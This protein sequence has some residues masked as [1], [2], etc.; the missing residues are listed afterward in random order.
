[1]IRGADN[2]IYIK[3]L[4]LLTCQNFCIQDITL[5]RKLAT[6][7]S[8]EIWLKAGIPLLQQDPRLP[9]PL[10]IGE[11]TLPQN[12]KVIMTITSLHAD[13][14]Y[15]QSPLTQQYNLLSSW[16][17]LSIKRCPNRQRKQLTPMS[18]SRREAAQGS[19]RA[20][21]VNALQKWQSWANRWTHDL[22]GFQ[23]ICL[24]L[25]SHTRINKQ[26]HHTC[27]LFFLF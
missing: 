11:R 15:Y 10:K 4:Y 24:V 7:T 6:R 8:T 22:Q 13:M 23:N 14:E 18:M 5:G 25:I 21:H 27:N 16:T 19:G 20:I 12:Q 3:Q 17:K 2:E 1:M 26:V 9:I